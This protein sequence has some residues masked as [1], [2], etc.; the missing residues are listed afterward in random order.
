LL[1]QDEERIRKQIA[2]AETV[3]EREVEEF[4]T[5]HPKQRSEEQPA[6]KKINGT[7][8]ETVGEPPTESPSVPNID[9]TNIP[10]QETQSDQVRAEKQAQEE[11]NG[12]VVVENEE[13]TVIY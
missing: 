7:S 5:R 12:E 11:H 10:V 9:T 13:D 4:N 2:D 1:P 8:K 6:E 3:I